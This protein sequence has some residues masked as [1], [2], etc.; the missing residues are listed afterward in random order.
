MQV[1]EYWVR[2]VNADGDSLEVYYC[3]TKKQAIA[4]RDYRTDDHTDAVDWKLEKVVR[5][6]NNG[7]DIIDEDIASVEW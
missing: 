2:P 7:G 5:K 4:E 1:T 3:D 6:Y